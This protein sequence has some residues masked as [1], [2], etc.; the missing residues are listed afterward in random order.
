MRSISRF[1][2]PCLDLNFLIPI[3][4]DSVN[5]C[6]FSVYGS[7]NVLLIERKVSSFEFESL[8][9]CV[10]CV[11]ISQIVN[12]VNSDRSYGM[13]Q[14]TRESGSFGRLFGDCGYG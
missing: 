13:V 10:M 6:A 3:F 8:C 5:A 7:V 12:G 11:W 2:V 9:L 1:L 4:A 14:R